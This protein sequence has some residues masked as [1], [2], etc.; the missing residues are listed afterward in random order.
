MK[1]FFP[2][3]KNI[4]ETTKPANILRLL[5]SIVSCNLKQKFPGSHKWPLLLH[6]CPCNCYPAPPIHMLVHAR[7]WGP[8]S[9]CRTPA[10]LW[11]IIWGR[12]GDD[13]KLLWSPDSRVICFKRIV[14]SFWRQFCYSSTLGPCP[15]KHLLLPA[16]SQMWV[17]DRCTDSPFIWGNGSGLRACASSVAIGT[18]TAPTDVLQGRPGRSCCGHWLLQL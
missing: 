12:G 2:S 7:E 16:V 10:L 17:M 8:P 5:F 13:F 18:L 4:T 9:S 11:G 6:S 1:E 3:L 14:C 15:P